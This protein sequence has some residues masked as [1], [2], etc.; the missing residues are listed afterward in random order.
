MQ[1]ESIAECF[2]PA[3]RDNWSWKPIFGLFEWPFKAGFT[4][5][6]YHI[7]FCVGMS[8]IADDTSCFQAV[9]VT[10]TDHVLIA[11]TRYYNINITYNLLNTHNSEPIHAEII[12]D[13]VKPV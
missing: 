6:T 1:V 7:Y 13:T 9:H 10:S 2:W 12:K 5:T 3:L 8:H 4:V 11:C